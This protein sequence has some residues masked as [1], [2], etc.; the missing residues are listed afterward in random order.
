MAART[1]SPAEVREFA[2]S[3]GIKVGT[4]GRFSAELIADFNKGR[5]VKYT[6]R[7]FKPTVKVTA[8]RENAKGG[9]TPVSRQINVAEARAYAAANGLKVGTR[10]RVTE[11]V[12]KA[13]VLAN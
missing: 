1:A 4:R 5:K 8:L 11:D 12:L 9:K 3:K 6:P 2:A 7:A 10:G 13:F